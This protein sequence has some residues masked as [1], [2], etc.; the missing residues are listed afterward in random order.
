[1]SVDCISRLHKRFSTPEV[2]IIQDDGFPLRPG[3]EEFLGKSDYIGAPWRGDD[4]WITRR[5]L[6]TSNLVGN[7]GFSLR[8]HAICEEASRLWNAGWRHIPSCYLRQ[9]DFFYARL[10]PKW[11]RSYQ[12]KIHFAPMEAAVR[13]S[14]EWSSI[15][16][17][18]PFG[19]H[20]AAAFRRVKEKFPE[21]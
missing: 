15:P 8:S 21:F 20:S 9:E 17:S 6:K 19:F 10:L 2:L 11:S 13:F 7:G 4:D 14:V 1:M 18:M 16:D 5:L 3:L 12:R